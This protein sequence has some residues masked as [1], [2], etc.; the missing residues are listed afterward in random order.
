MK[1][2]RQEKRQPVPDRCPSCGRLPVIV[3]ARA[4]RFLVTCGGRTCTYDGRGTGA[5]EQDAV[6]KWNEEARKR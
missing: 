2:K 4:G 3:K 1:E 6:D 5:T